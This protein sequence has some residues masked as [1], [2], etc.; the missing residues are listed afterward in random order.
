MNGPAAQSRRHSTLDTRR[1]AAALAALAGAI[2]LYVAPEHFDE[3]FLFGMFFLVLGAAQLTLAATL[4]VRPLDRGWYLLCA[5]VTLAVAAL[6]IV[7][8][9]VGLPIGPEPWQP[10]PV[11]ALDLSSKAAELAFVYTALQLA[12]SHKRG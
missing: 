2:H 7:T 1:A 4:A 6:W 8:R 10:E 9:T 12:R 3:Y 11:G 5:A